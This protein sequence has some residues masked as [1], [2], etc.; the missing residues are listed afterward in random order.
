M[1]PPGG[2]QQAIIT[3]G[4][5]LRQRM[6]ATAMRAGRT[7]AHPHP[8]RLAISPCPRTQAGSRSTANGAQAWRLGMISRRLILM[9]G[10]SVAI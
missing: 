5:D 7:Q 2:G 4:T 10:G 9:C 8:I 1:P 3:T 6:K